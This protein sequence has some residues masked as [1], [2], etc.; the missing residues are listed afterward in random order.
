VKGE[1]TFPSVQL[2]TTCPL[3][4]FGRIRFC[5][6][7]PK[8]RLTEYILISS[9]DQPVSKTGANHCFFSWNTKSNWSAKMMSF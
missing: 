4:V 9:E 3:W 1:S 2:R 5:S 8:L 7:W 6:M